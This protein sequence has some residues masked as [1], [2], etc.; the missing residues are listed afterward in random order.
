MTFNFPEA[1]LTADLDSEDESPD[2]KYGVLRS[3]SDVRD[4]E[5]NTIPKSKVLLDREMGR[6][7]VQYQEVCQ[8]DLFRSAAR[9]FAFIWI[10]NAKCDVFVSYEELAIDPD[11]QAPNGSAMHG[12]P[13]RKGWP[14]HPSQERKLG[15]PALADGKE[16]RVAGELFLDVINDSLQWYVN[17]GSG[18]YC[19]ETPPTGAQCGA[20]HELF[21]DLLDSAVLVDH[22]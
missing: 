12:H 5:R 7:L 21:K 4:W 9:C 18:R 19:R 2:L 16:V 20:V 3:P 13:R 1:A 14:V 15:H 10:M 11:T 22:L 8:S 17:C 6:R